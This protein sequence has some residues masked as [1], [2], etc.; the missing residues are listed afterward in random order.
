[1]RLN[2]H[3]AIVCKDLILDFR[4]RVICP[5]EAI[6]ALAIGASAIRVLAI[7]S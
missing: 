2:G 7:A 5:F 6:G 1:M 3:K 4:K